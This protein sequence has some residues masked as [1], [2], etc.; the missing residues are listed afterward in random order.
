[1]LVEKLELA[2]HLYHACHQGLMRSLQSSMQA[3]LRYLGNWHNSAV[4][5]YR[6]CHHKLMQSL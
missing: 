4:H 1:M 5:L 3:T 2:R 6:A